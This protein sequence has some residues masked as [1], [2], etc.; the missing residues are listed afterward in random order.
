M[1][2][3]EPASVEV[4]HVVEVG[5]DEVWH[6]ACETDTEAVGEIL[7]RRLEA[8]DGTLLMMAELGCGKTVLVRGMARHLG[9]EPRQV[10]SPTYNLIHEYDAPHA[11]LVHV[12]LY[13]LEADE[14][15]SLGLDEL[16][17]GPGIKAVEWAERL[18]WSPP[19]SRRLKLR[20]LGGGR[21][22]IRL[23]A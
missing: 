5:G 19:A 23:L 8:Q 21:R 14:L 6:S 1:N 2:V 4:R 13:R 3:L 18:T 17:A 12:D 10:Q 15:D 7:A 22:E 9:I 16:L 20:D 11:R